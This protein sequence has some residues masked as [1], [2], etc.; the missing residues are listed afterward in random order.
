MGVILQIVYSRLILYFAWL[1]III[2]SP[3]L[4]LQFTIFI[5]LQIQLFIYYYYYYY[6][7]CYCYYYFLFFPLFSYNLQLVHEKCLFKIEGSGASAKCRLCLKCAIG[8]PDNDVV[9]VS[10]LLALNGFW[11]DYAA[12][13]V[14]FEQVNSVLIQFASSRTFNYYYSRW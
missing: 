3:L 12:S 11:A 10:L 5:A 9:L 2:F 6:F 4:L 14:D 7:I 1:F 8:T 13:A